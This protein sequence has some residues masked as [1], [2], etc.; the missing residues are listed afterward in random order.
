MIYPLFC[1]G[2][3]HTKEL[4]FYQKRAAK[5]HNLFNLQIFFQLFLSQAF[6]TLLAFAVAFLILI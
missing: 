3:K 4:T 5:I 1:K 2:L 6:Y